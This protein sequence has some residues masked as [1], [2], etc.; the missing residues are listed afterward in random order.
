MS[1]A[2]LVRL[3]SLI[4]VLLAT[5]CGGDSGRDR[6]DD[7]AGLADLVLHEDEAPPGS[8]LDQ[9][10]SGSIE[11]LRDV[12][13]PRS[14][15]PELPPLAKPVRRGFLAGHDAVYRG[16]EE[17]GLGEVASSAVRFADA[18]Q[19][20]TF[21]GYLRE[22]QTHAISVG[23]SESFETP[24]LGEEGYGWHRTVPGGETSGCSW[25]RGELVFTLTLSGQLGEAPAERAAELARQIDQRL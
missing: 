7:S 3:L 10:A 8:R 9:G 11:S 1:A 13:P 2:R 23:A 18:G 17:S 24:G 25:R 12:L 15:A 5:S 6:T 4:V 16:D 21:L 14:D 22:A 19:A 20:A